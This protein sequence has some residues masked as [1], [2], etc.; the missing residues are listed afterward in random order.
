MEQMKRM[1]IYESPIRLL[2]LIALTIFVTHLLAMVAFALLPQFPMWIESAIESFLLVCLLFPVLYFF[3]FRPLLLHIAEREQAEGAMRESESK[4]RHLFEHLSDAALLVDVETGRI[5]DT[6]SQAERLLGL[7]RGEIIGVNQTKLYPAGKAGEQQQFFDNYAR[8]ESPA[9]YETEMARKDG[10]LT[11]VRIS[12]I[13][14]ILH[15]RRLI[16]ELV[17]DLANPAEK[18]HS[19]GTH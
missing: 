19:Q 13:P 17:R 15:G 2:G 10:T 4:Y 3:S 7:T 6:N 1:A 11:P 14:T 16:L 18:A 8:Q 9:E 12:G 5:L